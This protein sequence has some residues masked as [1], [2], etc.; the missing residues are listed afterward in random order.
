MSVVA[1]QQKALKRILGANAACSLL[2]H[3]GIAK[4]HKYRDFDLMYQ[5]FHRAVPAQSPRA[6]LESLNKMVTGGAVNPAAAAA[7]FNPLQTLASPSLMTKQ[8][9]SG[10][11]WWRG[12]PMPMV[13]SLTND[14]MAMEAQLK[15]RLIEQGMPLRGSFFHLPDFEPVKR[16]QDMSGELAVQ[17]L[18]VAMDA[19]RGWWR[20]R[21]TLP[22]LSAMADV[23]GSRLQWF[24]TLLDQVKQVGK[25]VDVLVASP[26]TLI[27]FGLFVSQQESRFV[28]LRELFP[29]LKVFA[30]NG[31]DLAVQRTELG[32]MFQG[33]GGIKW[34]QWFHNAAGMH[35]WQ[36]DMNIR[37]RLVMKLDGQVF[38]EFVPIEDVYPDGR[39]V[40]NYRR[41][42]VGQV[43]IGREYA[44][45]VASE[46]GLMGISSGQVVRIL[47][48][49]PFYVAMRGPLLRLCGLGEGFREDGVV[50]AIGNINMA[51][52]G[53]GVFI[54]ELLMGHV[55]SDRRPVWLVELSRP[56]TEVGDVVMDSIA[57]RLHAE[58]DLRFEGYR[59]GVRN[60]NIRP[61]QVNLVPM[62]TFAAAQSGVAEYG[63]FD[64]SPDATQV[65]RI[66]G[67]AWQSKTIEGVAS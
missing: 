66:L 38:Y 51:L 40:R 2:S 32:F 55:M 63:H 41:L 21:W 17:G 53:H 45:L 67:V 25:Q 33:L 26:K 10:A 47:Q 37:Q 39:F 42:H 61:P 29:N 65:K 49:E 9:L 30:F 62:G 35:L 13:P 11:V 6:W 64:H 4:L 22:R 34:V 46:A 31:Y 43:E 18:T 12:V 5:T 44:L 57:K 36:D 23:G 14:F 7:A 20:K 19:E 24:S 54:R 48:R 28:P 8:K 50:E 59:N 1:D 15:R 56:L 52:S 58:M 60:S 16:A 27:D 3:Y